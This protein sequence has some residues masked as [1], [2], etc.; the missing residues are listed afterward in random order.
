MSAPLVATSRSIPSNRLQ[1]RNFLYGILRKLRLPIYD[2]SACPKCWCE[3]THDCWDDHTMAC[4]DNNKT[5]AHHYIR[6]GWAVALQRIIALA[7]YILPTTKLDTEKPHLLQCEPGAKPLDISFDIDPVPSPDA[8]AVSEYA[9]VGGNITITSP[10]QSL[11][12]PM[13]I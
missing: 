11:P 7:R 2:P 13:K 6:D 1:I 4:K 9:C 5:I 12:H 3:Q 10:I 8:L